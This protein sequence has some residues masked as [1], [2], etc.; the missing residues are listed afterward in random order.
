MSKKFLK[1]KKKEKLKA[2]QI[3]E[4]QLQSRILA[5]THHQKIRVSHHHQKKN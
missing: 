1:K 3:Q 5:K 4:L 2:A